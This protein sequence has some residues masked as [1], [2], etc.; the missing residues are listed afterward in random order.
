MDVATV[1]GII[2]LIG[3]VPVVTAWTASL[4]SWRRVARILGF[5]RNTPVDVVVTTSGY[6]Q[7]PSGTSRSYRT[8]MGE[9]QAMGSVARALGAY[10]RRKT[11]RVHMSVDIR[12][13]LD[14]DVV[15][16]GGPLLNDTAVDFINAF[17]RCYPTAK[18]L[19]DATTQSME[20]GD[21]KRNGFDL[22]LENDIPGQDLC[23]ILL[24]WDLF[25]NRTRDTLC[26]GFTTY[27]TAAAAE[28]LFTDMTTRRYR[29]TAKHLKRNYG[30]AIVASARIVNQQTTYLQ[31]EGVWTFEQQARRVVYKP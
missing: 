26:A 22:R 14:S 16:L 2:G 12:N 9:V 18:V 29:R 23:L 28:L 25:E 15:V 7:H 17:Q 19:H 24:A 30:A 8:N 21:F 27:G 11:P 3:I 31:V 13:R 4:L 6:T 5:G 10:Y 20:I 1:V